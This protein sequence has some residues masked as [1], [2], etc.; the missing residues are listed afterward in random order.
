MRQV[1]F[2]CLFL[3]AMNARAAFNIDLSTVGSIYGKDDRELVT[4]QSTK[5]V[6]ELSRSV[7]LIVSTDL[8]VEN[9]FK[10]TIKAQTLQETLQMCVDERFSNKSA[11]P[12]CTG[13]LIG[14][15]LMATA[16]HCFQTSEDCMM[17]KV[18][19]DVDSKKQTKKGYS[20]LNSNVFS[21][22][23]IVAQSFDGE[24]DFTIIKLDRV[25]KKRPALKL[26]LKNKIADN[27]RVFMIGHPFGLPLM[28][29]KSAKVNHNAS[30]ISFTAG[31]DSFEG[32]SGSPV[33]NASTLEVEGILV[34]GQQDIV[35]DSKNECYRN[36]QYEED[37]G[38]E[39]IF[40]IS[41]LLPFLQ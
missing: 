6:Q 16:G 24:S 21:C 4:T 15:D 1:L 27:A 31:L 11:L 36:L 25:P 38:A 29:S 28:L 9:F 35:L 5:E 12:G 7:A 37:K 40:R 23:S 20:V 32:N 3:T 33:F 22:Q 17:K 10:T 19:F 14:P 39:G 26:N 18:I 2:L 30:D 34:N 13:F 8:L 41:G